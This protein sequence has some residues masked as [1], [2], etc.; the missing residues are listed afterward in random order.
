MTSRPIRDGPSSNFSC[1]DKCIT[2]VQIANL[3]D[4]AATQQL[5]KSDCLRDL[6]AFA[7]RVTSSVNDAVG[8]ASSSPKLYVF[9]STLL[10]A[11]HRSLVSRSKNLSSV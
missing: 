6:L 7:R 8:E 11:Q 3:E 1:I 10:N 2:A 4:D 5:Q 9:F